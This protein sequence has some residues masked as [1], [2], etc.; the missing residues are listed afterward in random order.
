MS[1]FIKYVNGISP[2]SKEAADDLLKDLKIKSFNK[3]DLLLKSGEVCKYFY[4]IE[5][6]LTKSFSYN[7]DKEFIMGF[8]QE[9][10]LFTELSSYLAQKPSKYMLI[11][12]EK[13]TVQYIHRDAIEKLCKKHHSFETLIRKLFTITSACF[14][15]RINEM[16]EENAKERYD[17]FINDHP[18]LL[19]RI[20]LGDL[21]NYIGITQVSLSRIRA[22]K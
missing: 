16:L 8:F 21:A 1:D 13:T 5:E 12:L 9:N 20:S 6:G 3:N 11:A 19:Q 15:D 4:Y 7:N 18:S 14:M 10:M 17:N 2:L 22:A